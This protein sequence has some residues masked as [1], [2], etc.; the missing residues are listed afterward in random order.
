[1]RAHWKW[2]R[3]RKPLLALYRGALAPFFLGEKMIK[4]LW[5]LLL[6]GASYK[7]PDL[8][9]VLAV[10]TILYLIA[11]H[12][13]VFTSLS[14]LSSSEVSSGSLQNPISTLL[15]SL[16]TA[17]VLYH[18]SSWFGVAFMMIPFTLMS[19][20]MLTMQ[21]LIAFEIIAIVPADEIDQEEE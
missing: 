12:Y 5:A 7:I 18:D 21:A 13:I 16:M 10:F 9:D 11:Y 4:V 14:G 17:F 15:L 3:Q 19:I 8:I 6:L 1:M 20:A 2:Q